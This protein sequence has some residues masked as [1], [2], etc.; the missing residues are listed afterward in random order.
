MPI[1]ISR[2]SNNYGPYQ[3]PEKLIPLVII[4]ALNNKTIPLYGDGKNIRDWIYVLDHVKGIW[5]VLENG[6]AGDVYNIGGDSEMENI[7][8]IKFILNK[9]NKPFL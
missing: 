4:N 1:L 8:I 7:D 5:A 2:C 9:L 3:F 6:K